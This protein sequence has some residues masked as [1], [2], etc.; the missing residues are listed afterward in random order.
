MAQL[1]WFGVN[2]FLNNFLNIQHSYISATTFIVQTYFLFTPYCFRG[3]LR[4]IWINVSTDDNNT[5][6]WQIS[7][8]LTEYS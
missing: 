2:L 1:E 5:F 3:Y 4:H 7:I 6:S 8:R